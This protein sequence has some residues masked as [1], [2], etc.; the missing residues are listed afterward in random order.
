MHRFQHPTTV[1]YL[2]LF[3]NKIIRQL[4]NNGHFHQR[5]TQQ[6]GL[7]TDFFHRELSVHYVTKDLQLH[8]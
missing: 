5:R 8:V 6:R 7:E 2:G 1:K 3:R 4:C